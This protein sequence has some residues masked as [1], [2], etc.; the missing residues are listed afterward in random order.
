MLATLSRHSS[1]LYRLRLWWWR[2]RAGRSA[3]RRQKTTV[4][5]PR[6]YAI[7][8]ARAHLYACAADEGW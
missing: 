1:W 8:A 7:P 3:V 4:R 5:A 2:F 6:R